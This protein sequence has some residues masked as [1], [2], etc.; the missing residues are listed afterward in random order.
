MQNS[1]QFNSS[2]PQRITSVRRQGLVFTA[3][4]VILLLPILWLGADLLN[5][6][7]KQDVLQSNSLNLSAHSLGQL[8]REVLRLSIIV[9]SHQELDPQEIALQLDI[10]QSR[11]I[12]MQRNKF[13]DL[14]PILY[15]A[16]NNIDATWGDLQATLAAWQA[17]T[18]HDSSRQPLAQSLVELEFEIND[19][20]RQQRQERANQYIA[21]IEVR[22]QSLQLLGVI[23]LVFLIFIALA[24][25]NTYRFI[26]ERQQVMEALQ[27][28]KEAAEVANQAKTNFL[29][30]MG[31]EL[32]TPLNH[33]LGYAQILQREQDLNSA[34]RNSIDI[35]S[36]SGHDLLTL[37]ND[38]LDFAKMDA[39]KIELLPT[40]FYLPTF[41]EGIVELIRS[42]MNGYGK[43]LSFVYQPDDALPIGIQADDKRLR[44]ILINLL[45]NSVKFTEQGQI[46]FKVIRW[47][48]NNNSNERVTIR[49]EI[50][51]TGIGISA[52]Q[53]ER[54]CLPFEQVGSYLNHSE[55]TGLG[56]AMTQQLLILMGSQL[57]VQ[58][59]VGKGST[60]CFELTVP[61]ATDVVKD[62]PSLSTITVDTN[63]IIAPPQEKLEALSELASLG[64]MSAIR[65]WATE[66]ELLEVKYRP[67]ANKVREFAQDFEEEEIVLLV[68][69]YLKDEE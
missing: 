10:T 29:A 34:Q 7:Q 67:F 11:F 6:L 27:E 40:K 57:Q 16:L 22:S 39:H 19:I 68:E 20:L 44:Q 62:K 35:I 53:L 46:T 2:S 4:A 42:S 60:F 15:K 52:K 17:D 41:L 26:R 13:I 5:Q 58:S 63:T 59:E 36:Q 61:L 47:G 49:F 37:I 21:L 56:L 1:N 38:I 28:A 48:T 25:Y 24:A 30:N 8:Q 65:K 50:I 23:S 18:S 32:R 31:H 12:I 33:I 55:G 66:M 43:N 3:I 54:I 64:K 69:E 45:D 9:D 14:S 51:D